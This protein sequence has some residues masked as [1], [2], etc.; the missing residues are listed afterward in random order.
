MKSAACENPTDWNRF[1]RA[2][3]RTPPVTNPA[4]LP[5]ISAPPGS[6]MWHPGFVFGAATPAFQSDGATQVGG[7]VASIW[8]TYAA[9][10]GKGDAGDPG[11]PACDHSRRYDEDIAL[12][13][14][15]GFDAYRFS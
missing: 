10:P 2:I 6:A 1:H 9:A 15:L 7:R 5:P 13:A 14:G 11:E 3:A 4:D 12:L 8:D